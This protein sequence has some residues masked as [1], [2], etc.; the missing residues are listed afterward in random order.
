MVLSRF[1]RK[2]RSK[3]ESKF[4]RVCLTS[5]RRRLNSSTRKWR[6]ASWASGAGWCKHEKFHTNSSHSYEFK[7][8]GTIAWKELVVCLVSNFRPPTFLNSH[9][10]NRPKEIPRCF[11][12]CCM[13]EIISTQMQ[14][15]TDPRRDDESAFHGS[16]GATMQVFSMC[17]AESGGHLTVG[18]Q[19]RLGSLRNDMSSPPVLMW[20]A[21]PFGYSNSW[22]PTTQGRPASC[23]NI[24]IHWF[25]SAVNL[26]ISEVSRSSTSRCDC[27]GVSL[28]SVAQMDVTLPH[29]APRNAE[30]FAGPA[31]QN[32]HCRNCCWA[33]SGLMKRHKVAWTKIIQS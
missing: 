6:T 33:P 2:V 12:S 14:G 4:L 27:L 28:M 17:I 13:I 15:S 20:F 21:I 25:A 7:G 1:I 16:R 23:T 19:N 3:C 29:A 30:L 11:S 31:N 5:V 8:A 10:G 26:T 9:A 32:I 18:G 24:L 22:G